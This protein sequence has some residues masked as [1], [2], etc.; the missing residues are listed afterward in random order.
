MKRKMT[1]FASPAKGAA[2]GYVGLRL[3]AMASAPPAVRSKNPSADSI[4]VSATPVNFAP[5]SQ[6]NS[7]RVRRQKVLEGLSVIR[8]RRSSVGCASAHVSRDQNW[9]RC[10]YRRVLKAHPAN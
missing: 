4:A 8:L 7:R 2:L 6:R 10:P 1:L 9:Y 3:F 5:A